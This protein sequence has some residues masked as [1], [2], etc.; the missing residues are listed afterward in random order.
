MDETTL[1]LKK[2]LSDHELSVFN[3]EMEKYK[4]GTGLAY[5]LW[6]FLGTLGIHKFY[7]GKVIF[8][9]IYVVLGLLAWV[10]LIVGLSIGVTGLLAEENISEGMG[11][12][13]ALFV[14]CI[15]I[16]GIL[17]LIPRFCIRSCGKRCPP[18]IKLFAYHRLM[19]IKRFLNFK[20]WDINLI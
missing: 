5:L 14:I 9:I 8:G 20:L 12:W 7:I 18:Q 3:S 19:R 6:F 1:K 15:I 10:S 4:K 16:V 2:D 13:M 17:L 11:P